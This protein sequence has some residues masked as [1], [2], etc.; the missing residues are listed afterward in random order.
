VPGTAMPIEE[1]AFAVLDVETTGLEPHARVVEIAC[2]RLVAFR[3]VGRLQSLIQPGIP[4]PERATAI[5][6][7][8]DAAVAGAP[9]FAEVWPELEPLLDD[10]VLVAHNAPFDLHYLS[11]EK[12]RAGGA[13]W[14]GPVVDTLRLARN[15]VL[16]PSYA[17]A[18]L[19]AA[20]ALEP[21]PSHRAMADVLTTA[22]LLQ[23]LLRRL[24]PQ[25]RTVGDL[26]QAQEPV[27]VAWEE[28]AA[29]GVE[30]PMVEALSEAARALRWV[31]IEYVGRAGVSHW[32]FRPMSLERNG[33]LVYL[34][35]ELESPREIRTFR[36]DRIRSV[37]PATPRAGGPAA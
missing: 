3:E 35:C 11:S 31:E 22:A 4:I 15:V 10:A 27:P 13:A 24:G 36:A 1:A 21:V 20:L 30:P 7:I 34:R 25:V 14:Q 33:P 37:V 32:R 28:A 2:V 5:S 19:C 6:G 29:L 17:L 12:K 9:G 18:A 8:D 23:E 16:L 26:L